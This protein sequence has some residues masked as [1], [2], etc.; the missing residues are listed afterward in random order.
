MPTTSQAMIDPLG[1]FMAGI[2]KRAHAHP[3]P[4]LSTRFDVVIEAG[5]VT[6]TT[7]RIFRNTE[8]MPIEAILTFPMPVHATLFALEARIDGRLLQATAQRR[9]AARETYEAAIDQGKAAVLHEEVL[10]G[11]HTLSIANLRPG[12]DIE[13]TMRWAATLAFVAGAGWLRIPQT[14]GDVYGC[15]GFADTDELVADGRSGQRARLH[16]VGRDVAVSVAGVTLID[17]RA[18]IPLDRPIDIS[19][20]AWPAA[21]LA[22]RAADGRR[23]DMVITPSATGAARAAITVLLDCSGSMSERFESG[24]SGMTN[25]M[26]ATAVI[27]G[28]GAALAEGDALELW[29]F[30][31]DARPIGRL[32]RFD[33]RAIGNLVGRLSHPQG[34]TETGHAVQTVARRT[35][36]CDILLITDGKSHALDVQALARLGRRISVLLIGEDS[37]EA[38]VGI[39]RR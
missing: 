8:A 29:E 3:I 11:I 17:G 26:A 20:A 33:D 38:N 19:T 34:G 25:H 10:R 7:T 2:R 30:N 15:S 31:H 13:V 36:A 4:L 27:G 32:A 35:E 5:L 24:R 23:V 37:L 6:A 1:I 28:I 14:A 18:E 22:G 21:T 9:D 39:S 12:G 16:I